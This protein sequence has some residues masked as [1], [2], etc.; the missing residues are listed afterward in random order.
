[1]KVFFIGTSKMGTTS[2]FN[3]LKD[4]G[5]RATHTP[6]YGIYTHLES[7]QEG[8]FQKHDYFLDGNFHNFH[9][10]SLW[11]PDAKFVL[12]DREPKAWILSLFNWL[13]HIDDRHMGDEKLLVKLSRMIM[14]KFVYRKILTDW[15]VYKKRALHF[16]K[17]NKN[18]VHVNL[19]DGG[20]EEWQHLGRHLDMDLEMRW[21]NR[22]E[23][24]SFPN[25]I[26]RIYESA[27]RRSEKESS[28]YPVFRSASLRDR[29]FLFSTR[30]LGKDFIKERHL[31]K[32]IKAAWH[33]NSPD[34]FQKYHTIV[35]HSARFLRVVLCLGIRIVSTR[36]RRLSPFIY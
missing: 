29:L 5:V 19:V 33:S 23:K 31:V 1:M 13:S 28:L 20:K 27:E 34:K 8:F 16:F 15:L 24:K 26:S 32:N 30:V 7:P 6:Q 36:S 21:E 18:F 22:Q 10:L 14:G 4:K 2:I 25:W 9:H 11:F 12:L 35:D 3:A 17:G